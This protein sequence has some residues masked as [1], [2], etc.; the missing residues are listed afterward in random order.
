MA[1]RT[2]NGR[3]AEVLEWIVDGCPPG[4]MADSSYKATAA[5]LQSRR[6]VKVTKRGGR[7]SATATAAGRFFA[8]HNRYPHG[9]WSGEKAGSGEQQLAREASPV[10]AAP[11]RR[12]TGSRPVDQMLADVVAAGGCLTVESDAGGY[13]ANLVASAIRYGKVPAGK[14]LK[15]E[16]G[17][18]WMERRIC[19]EDQPEW[20][21]A[22]L[23]PIAVADSL[24]NPHP[25]VKELKEDPSRLKLGRDTRMRTLRIL[26]ALAKAAAERGYKVS[27]PSDARGDNHRYGYL[28]ITVGGH[29]HAI[30]IKELNDKRPHEPTPKELRDKARNPWKQIPTHD[31]V[32][33]GRL[34][35]TVLGGWHVNQ[36]TF[37]DTK[38][39]RLEDRLPAVLQEVELRV[40]AEQE[41][42]RK[43]EIERQERQREWEQTFAEAKVAVRE[44]HRAKVLMRQVEEWQQAGAL[45][46]FIEAAR[47]HA[48]ELEGSARDEADEWLTWARNHA[49]TL[50][51]LN[52][53]LAMP[54]DPEFTPEAL[55]LHTKGM[56]PHDP[57]R[58]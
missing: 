42:E 12:V 9:H 25:V 48:A 24:R 52:Q 19:L 55:R 3:Q 23:E 6:L 56:S 44:D 41:Q 58:W 30:D 10:V 1:E 17:A 38:T 43:R 39:I 26:D 5:A 20:M 50:N 29:A 22:E 11:G 2:V 18:S 53:P 31:Q 27:A 46:A 13:W 36:E 51:P 54:A 47:A 32:P 40:A 33:S 4:V 15:I 21:A 7:W 37:A 49:A 35:L 14:V 34:I 45:A 8:E 57:D 28:K 16:R